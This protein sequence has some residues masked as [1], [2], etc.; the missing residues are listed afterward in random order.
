MFVLVS[1]VVFVVP[2]LIVLARVTVR[3]KNT[4]FVFVVSVLWL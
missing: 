1:A 2:S 4:V 3:V